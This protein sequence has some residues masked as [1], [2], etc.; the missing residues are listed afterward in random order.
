MKKTSLNKIVCFLVLSFLSSSALS[1]YDPTRPGSAFGSTSAKKYQLESVLVS[2]QRTIAIINGTIVSVGDRLGN[3]VVF[4]IDKEKV[5]L[6]DGLRT[7]DLYL[8][9]SN[10]KR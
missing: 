6:K 2:P 10:V 9:V 7:L 1:F 8:P 4:S 5:V 3:R